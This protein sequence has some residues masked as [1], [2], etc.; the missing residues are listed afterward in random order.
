MAANGKRRETSAK[1]TRCRRDINAK[2]QVVHPIATRFA[3]AFATLQNFTLRRTPLSNCTIVS[4]IKSY[5]L[6]D[7]PRF[8]FFFPV[9]FNFPSPLLLELFLE[10]DVRP[11]DCEFFLELS[12]P[13]LPFQLCGVAFGVFGK[14]DFAGDRP[15]TCT[16]R[17]PFASPEPARPCP[18]PLPFSFFSARNCSTRSG[19]FEQM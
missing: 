3:P 16:L 11:L 8:P 14:A 7:L 17:E 4:C 2:T 18:F 13:D 19:C 9:P 5:F 6:L 15:R 1:D 10:P 12:E